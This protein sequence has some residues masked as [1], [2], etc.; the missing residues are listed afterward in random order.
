MSSC[1]ES[2]LISHS[3]NFFSLYCLQYT[4]YKLKPENVAVS[5]KKVKKQSQKNLTDNLPHGYLGHT[6]TYYTTWGGIRT[7][8]LHTPI[9]SHDIVH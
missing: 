5:N 4:E 2:Y 7:H 8:K 1:R 6:V 3:F 9:S